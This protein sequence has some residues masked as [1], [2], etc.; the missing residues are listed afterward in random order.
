MTTTSMPASPNAANTM[1]LSPQPPSAIKKLVGR[2]LKTMGYTLSRSTPQTRLVCTNLPGW[3]SVEEA[4]ALYTLA[5]TTPASRILEIGHFLGRSTSAICEA[6]RDSGGVT[7]FN[8][9]DLGF[10]SADEFIAHYERV[11]ATVTTQVPKECEELV[12]S[13]KKT[14]TEIAKVNLTRYGLDKYVNLI[15]GD[16]TALDSTQYGLIFC[17][18]VHDRSEIVLNLPYV[19]A[20]STD[21]CVWAFHDMFPENV[22]AVLAMSPA[23]LI[24]VVD[25][26]GIFRFQRPAQGSRSRD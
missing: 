26:L 2:A 21:D 4:E 7:E 15:S 5:A 22:E 3:F 12:Y 9:Y 14:T 11:H 25:T 24:R 13:Q 19:M 20:A 8:S 17:D 23:R 1:P 16:F 18:A 6:I 10:R